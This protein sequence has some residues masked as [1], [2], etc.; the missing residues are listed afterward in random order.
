MLL[1]RRKNQKSS[2]ELVQLLDDLKALP[3]IQQVNVVWYVPVFAFIH[4]II[5]VA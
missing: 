2:A 3:D 1:I 4:F 5:S